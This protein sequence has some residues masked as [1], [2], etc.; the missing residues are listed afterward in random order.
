MQPDKSLVFYGRI[1]SRS[2]GSSGDAYLQMGGGTENAKIEAVSESGT[3]TY[4]FNV[5]LI[6]T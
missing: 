2:F 4:A 3:G 6:L 5:P 1:N